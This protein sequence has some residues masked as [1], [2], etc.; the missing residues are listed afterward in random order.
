MLISGRGP[1]TP[2]TP[3]FP[4]INLTKTIKNLPVV[5]K[6]TEKWLQ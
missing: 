6:V 2:S 5:S 4:N 1:V 3:F